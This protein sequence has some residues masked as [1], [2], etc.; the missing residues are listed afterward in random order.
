MMPYFPHYLSI[1]TSV[2]LP[3]VG[4]GLGQGFAT[5]AA[6][7]AINQQPGAKADIANTVIL[8]MAL[9]ETAAI[10]GVTLAIIL[11]FG[12]LPVSSYAGLAEI[13]MACAV[14]IPGFCIGLS[15]ALP[16][17]QACFSIARQPFFA[18]KITRFMLVTQS[19]I[20]TSIIF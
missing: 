14:A 7:D 1:A 11:L 6:L 2:A 9:I 19:L 5:L 4:V 17:H 12:P 20:Q 8:G 13:G 3:A 16:L 18:A 15:S 10:M